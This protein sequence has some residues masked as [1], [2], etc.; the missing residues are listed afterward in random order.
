M[1]DLALGDFIPV[2]CIIPSVFF[3]LGST[4]LINLIVEDI[5]KDLSRLKIKKRARGSAGRELKMHFC[6][7]VEL[8]TD[9]KKLCFQFLSFKKETLSFFFPVAVEVIT[10]NPWE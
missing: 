9:V 7:I 5:S 10:K 4:W 8:Y 3:C 6:G 2:L 1:I